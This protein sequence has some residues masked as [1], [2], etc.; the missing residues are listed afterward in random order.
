MGT[1]QL[2]SA[3]YFRRS[4]TIFIALISGQIMFAI[5]VLV[6][7]LT[8]S[9]AFTSIEFPHSLEIIMGILLV[10]TLVFIQLSSILF[11]K[12]LAAIKEKTVLKEIMADYQTALIIRYAI[13]EFPV[14]IAIGAA[15]YTGQILLLS[16]ALIIIIVFFYLKP[17]RERLKKDLELNQAECMLIDDPNAIVAEVNTG[18]YTP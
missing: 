10:L 3:A 11:K 13:L 4:L 16:F 5:G 17:G 2:S 1:Q 14:F 15:I 8:N 9:I 7:I 12:K 18:N 6:M